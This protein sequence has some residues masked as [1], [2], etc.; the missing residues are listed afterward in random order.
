MD[1]WLDVWMD[2]WMDGCMYVCMYVC[3][4]GGVANIF[5]QSCAQIII[6]RYMKQRFRCQDVTVS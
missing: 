2:G 6:N 3:I 4:S 5:Y 1:G